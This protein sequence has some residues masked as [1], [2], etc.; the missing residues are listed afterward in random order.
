MAHDHFFACDVA[1]SFIM[2]DF[3]IPQLTEDIAED[4]KVVEVEKLSAMCPY[5]EPSYT[6]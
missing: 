3:C 2:N 5:H 4:V 6:R 1:P